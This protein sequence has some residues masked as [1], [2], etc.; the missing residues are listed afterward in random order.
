M[1]EAA[2][3]R[4]SVGRVA[5]VVVVLGIVGMWAYIFSRTGREKPIDQ[6][7]D[8]TFAEQAQPLCEAATEDLIGA[9]PARTPDARANELERAND[10]LQAL[11]GELAAIAPE[12]GGDADLV[13]QWL[14]DWDTYLGDRDEY[15]EA[16]RRDGDAAEFLVTPRAGRQITLTMEHFAE[17]NDMPDCAPPGDV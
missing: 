17:I 8:P 9:T 4:W 7:D 12:R 13:G 15:V 10:R 3:R 11:V 14:D 1:D 5:A 16:L 2:P 6:L